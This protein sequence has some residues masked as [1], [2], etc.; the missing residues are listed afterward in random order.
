[1]ALKRKGKV[2]AAIVASA[3]IVLTLAMT[4]LGAA[5]RDWP[6]FLRPSEEYSADVAKAVRRLWTDAT[7][8]RTV[9]A[10]PAA[11]PL[12]F[13]LRFVDAPDVT[14]AAA[15]H[16]GLTTYEVRRL[17]GD[18]YEATDGN[19]TRGVYRVLVRD[20]A[21]RVIVSWGTHQ[22]SLLGTIGGSALTQLEF[23]DE[24]A[25]AA[26]R[27]DVNVIIDHGLIAGI[28][29]PLLLVFGGMVDRKLTEA[30]RTAA[31][32]AAWARAEPNEFCAWLGGAFP[33]ER[34]AELRNVFDECVE[35]PRS[36]G[37]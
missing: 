4:A 5:P 10:E 13:Y 32:A 24:G 2:S 21:R 3:I 1:M 37:M 36:A 15:R 28:T 11:V 29:R 26:Q 8:T 35:Q 6:P 16:L 25:R 34:R 17:G 27:L 18:W 30:F 19:R 12:A 9:S 33:G 7:F 14:A 23:G 31:S 20:G 22:G